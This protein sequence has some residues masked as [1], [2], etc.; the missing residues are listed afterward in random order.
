VLAESLSLACLA[1]HFALN[2]QGSLT[3]FIDTNLNSHCGA[4]LTPI[5]LFYD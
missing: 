5:D 2:P 4:A 1:S 3:T